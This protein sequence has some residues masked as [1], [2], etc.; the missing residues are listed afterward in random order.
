[1]THKNIHNSLNYLLET[2]QALRAPRGCPWDAEQTPESLAPYILEEAC[3]L[4]D[5]IE[6]GAPELILDELG[7]LLLQ[8]VFQAQIFKERDQFDFHDIA[9]GIADKLVRRH[10]HVFARSH[11]FQQN[12]SIVQTAELDKQWDEIKRSETT[13]NKTCLADHLPSHLPALQ[14]AQKLISRTYRVGR[15]NELHEAQSK[16]LRGP[17]DPEDSAEPAVSNLNEQPD[18]ETL[19]QALFELVKFA[20]D[21]NLDAET[22]LRKTTRAVIK[23]LDHG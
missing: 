2:M 5:A 13:H 12:G 22:A 11:D 15:Q 20:Q 9:D 8:V 7:D 19:G 18:E 4:I 6:D 23:H 3:E 10:P 16:L 14:R 21:N 1:M 17:N